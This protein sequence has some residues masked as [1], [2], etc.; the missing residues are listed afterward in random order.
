M[1]LLVSAALALLFVYLV[2]NWIRYSAKQTINPR[3]LCVI[4]GD[5]VWIIAPERSVS[6][7]IRLQN[8]DAPELRRPRSRKELTRAVAATEFLRETIDR[9]RFAT[10]RRKS[11]DRYGRTLARIAIDGSDLGRLLVRAGHAKRWT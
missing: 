5:T 10:I 11:K 9:A 8:V 1:S 3:D 6:E 4:D 7:K 2:W